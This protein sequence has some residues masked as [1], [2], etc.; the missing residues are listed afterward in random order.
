MPSWNAILEE[1]QRGE[2][3]YD[4]L[5]R[6]YL[7]QLHEHTGRNVIIYYSGWLQKP[8]LEQHGVVDFGINDGDKN[9][10]MAAVY[11]LD[12]ARGLDLF[13]TLLAAT[14]RPLSPWST[15]SARCSGLTFAHSYPSWLSP[16]AP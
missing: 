9:G 5:R 1:L 6:Q 14:W 12:R 2:I 15:T 10:F 16:A 3:T 11:G 8:G 7:R 13:C 4:G